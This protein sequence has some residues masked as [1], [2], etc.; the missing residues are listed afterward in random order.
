MIKPVVLTVLAVLARPAF[1]AITITPLAG[2]PTYSN[3]SVDTTVLTPPAPPQGQ[4][5]VVPVQLYDGGMIG[6]SKPVSG[7]FLGWSIELSVADMYIGDSASTVRAEFLN[8]ANTLAARGGGVTIRVGGNTQD[9]AVLNLNIDTTT[10][11]TIAKAVDAGST[12]KTD[13]PIIEFSV[14]LFKAMQAVGNAVKVG[15]L[16]GI[17]FVNLDADENASL[18]MQ[19]SKT[20]LGDSLIGLQLANEPDLYSRNSKR[21]PD[22]SIPDFF[23]DTAT[24]IQRLPITEPIIIGPSV[25]CT[26]DIDTV[27]SDGYLTKFAPSIK[28]IDALHYP[29]NNCKEGADAVVPQNILPYYLSHTNVQALVS[30]YLGVVSTALAAGKQFIMMETNTASCGGF[31]GVSNSFAS[32]LW[33]VDYGMQMA[34]GNFSHALYHSGGQDSYYNPFT[35]PPGNMKKYYKWT[36]GPIFYANLVVAEALGKSGNAQ[37]IDLALDGNNPNRAGYAVYENGVASRAVL[38]NYVTEAG[39]GYTAQ[40]AIGGQK[41]GLPSVT[42]ASV[43]VKY[44]LAGSN[45]VSENYN[46]TWSGQTMGGLNQGGGRLTGTPDVQTIQCDAQT[47]LCSIPVPAPSVAL[48]FLTDAAFENSGGADAGASASTLAVPVATATTTGKGGKSTGT[49]G[50]SNNVDGTVNSGASALGVVGSAWAVGL[51]GV[52]MMMV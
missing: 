34:Y 16:F 33:G 48:V 31:P 51:V 11:D 45:S 46:I 7:A 42:P 8:Y 6:L 18:V 22:Y 10:G 43:R 28:L 40:I 25:C 24:M 19:N 39:R 30:P 35:P 29:N 12:A 27:I 5:A 14:D 38:V 15:W 44:L 23:A 50:T 13:T 4:N 26:W 37:V 20:Y 9:K 49:A 3:P 32:A 47:G 41:T 2:Y 1:S 21:G 52:I 36:T 17:P